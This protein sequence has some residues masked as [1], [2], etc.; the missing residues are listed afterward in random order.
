MYVLAVARVVHYCHFDRH[1][2]LLCLEVDDVVEEVVAV[3]ID[4]AHELLQSV[5]CMEHVLAG[6]AFFVGTH[7][8]QG[9]SDACIEVG[10]L[11][12]TA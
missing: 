1:A 2:L 4:I 6:V 12:H 7:V 9:D 10:E 8:A 5:L 11:T 3:T